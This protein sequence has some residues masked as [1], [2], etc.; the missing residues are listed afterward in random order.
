MQR[1]LDHIVHAVRDLDRAATFYRQLGFTVGARNCH[2]WGTHNHIVQLPGFFIEILGVGEPELLGRDPAYSELSQHFGAFNRDAIARGEG[3]SMLILES[4]DI[5]ADLDGFTKAD[6]AVSGEVQF[7]RTGQR[8]DGTPVTVGFSLVFGRDGR[9]PRTG[10]AVC[11]QHN[12][13]A[14]WSTQFQQHAN[15]AV[16]VNGVVLA[17][18]NPTDHHIFLTAFTGE[19][20]LHATSLGL[21]AHTPRG[22]V[23]IMEPVSTRDQFGIVPE[24]QGESLTLTALRIAV[25]SID[26]TEAVLRGS[27]IVF[28]HRLNALVIGPAQALGATL[29]FEQA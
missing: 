19:R 29:V 13:D 11:R 8:P 15:G 1:G 18:D 27:G 3:F 24:I 16:R 12:P 6:I 10:F 5:A 9:S 14:F 7:S 28:E 26:E 23:E 2:P 25:R 22:D 4:R 17:A 20:A 21:S